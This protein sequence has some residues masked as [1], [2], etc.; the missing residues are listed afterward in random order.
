MHCGKNSAPDA[1]LRPF[2]EF[3]LKLEKPEPGVPCG[4]SGR[5]PEGTA[6]PYRPVTRRLPSAAATIAGHDV[7][8]H[9][10]FFKATSCH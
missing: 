6:L 9:D 10:Y 1:H 8:G 7:L 4:I 3:R 2:A 5:A